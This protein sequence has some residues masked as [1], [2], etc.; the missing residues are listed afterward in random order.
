MHPPLTYS[1]QG[2]DNETQIEV[3]PT[4]GPVITKVKD[5]TLGMV[6]IQ[7]EP[8]AIAAKFK[9]YEKLKELILSEDDYYETEHGKAL[10]KSGL[11]KLGVAFNLD[12]L[13]VEE[14]KITKADDPTYVGYKFTIQCTAPNGRIT[15][16]VGFCDN[17]EK[18]R[19]D[20]NEHV[21]RAMAVTRGKERCYVTMMGAPE[22]K[23]KMP[24]G[25]EPEEPNNPSN[26]EVCHCPWKE[27]VK[28]DGGVCKTCK[29]PMTVSQIVTLEKMLKH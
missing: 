23:G 3:S 14:R 21:V 22:K 18:D 27:M 4:P 28:G 29:K 19:P 24:E 9:K 26:E 6:Q 12:T 1:M 13:I 17:T 25:K 15:M 10:G 8:E 5:N 2:D 16:D 20:A 7:E 11:Y